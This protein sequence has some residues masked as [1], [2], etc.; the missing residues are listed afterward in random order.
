LSLDPVKVENLMMI[1]SITEHYHDFVIHLAEDIIDKTDIK[2][3]PE[4]LFSDWE[5]MIIFFKSCGILFTDSAETISLRTKTNYPNEEMLS[6]WEDFICH[7]H[8]NSISILI[9]DDIVE[10]YITKNF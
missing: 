3:P 10:E 5:E 8:K 2:S 4:M 9:E 1:D 6:N 7:L